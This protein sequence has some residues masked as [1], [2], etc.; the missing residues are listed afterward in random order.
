MRTDAEPPAIAARFF[1]GE[2]EMAKETRAAGLD[3]VRS[4]KETA[5]IL[6]IS[7]QTLTRVQD[8]LPPIKISTRRI[9]YRDSDIS[10]F[11]SNRAAV[12]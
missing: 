11:L 10:K 9:G 1:N 5:E 6:G 7:V 12:A 2:R 3:R 8:E 4:R